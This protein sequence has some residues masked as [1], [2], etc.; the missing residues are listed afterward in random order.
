[1]TNKISLPIKAKSDFYVPFDPNELSS[2]LVDRFEKQVTLYPSNIALKEGNLR[3]TYSELNNRANHI[4][5][6]I[7][8]NHKDYRGPIAFLLDHGI[9][10]IFAIFGIL[11]S[12]N[13]YLALDSDFPVERLE[14]MLAD[15]GAPLV[16]TDS[17]N[18]DFCQSFTKGG[19]TIVN[20]DTIDFT[21][22]LDNPNLDIPLEA[23]ALLQYTSGSTGQPK[24]CILPHKNMIHLSMV[25][26]REKYFHSMD[27]HIYLL[28]ASFAAHIG[29][30]FNMLLNGGGVYP[31]DVKK[32]GLKK[33]AD[34]LVKEKITVF[35]AIPS[36]FRYFASMIDESTQF[37]DLRIL[38]LAGDSVLKKDVELFNKFFPTSCYFINQLGGTE[39]LGACNYIIP[40]GTKING[41]IVPVGY[42]HEGKKVLL[43]DENGDMVSTGEVGEIVVQSHYLSPGY[44]HRQDLTD[45]VFQSVP[46]KEN[47]FQYKTGDLGRRDEDGCLYHLGR[48]DNQVKIR[49]YRV[50]LAEII[51]RLHEYPF[52]KDAYVHAVTNESGEKQLIAYLVSSEKSEKII[53]RINRDL[54]NGLPSYM[55]PMYFEF[56]DELP[57]IPAGKIDVKKLPGPK[58]DQSSLQRDYLP[59]RNF[60]ERK[61]VEIWESLLDVHPIGIK[62]SFTELGGHSLSA[63][64]LIAELENH[65]DVTLPLS[66]L[67]TIQTIE[68]LAEVLQDDTR[69]TSWSHLVTLQPQGDKLPFFCIPAAGITALSFKKL[70]DYMS[71]DRPI[72]GIDYVGMDGKSDP[73]TTIPEIAEYNISLM[74]SVQPE[75]PYCLSGMCFGAVVAYEMAHQ[76]LKGG[77]KVGFLGVLDA[78]N[79]PAQ[80]IPLM[81]KLMKAGVDLNDKVFRGKL[82]IKLRGLDLRLNQDSV[83]DSLLDDVYRVF[84][85]HAYAHLCYSSAQL[86]STITLFMTELEHPERLRK[87]WQATTTKDLDVVV[88]PGVHGPLS[89]NV[90]EMGSFMDE[91]NVQTLAKL[92]MDKLDNVH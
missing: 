25:N 20:L 19:S 28:S 56:L 44:W 62:E 11:K 59:P 77:Q 74:K 15:S 9:N 89:R 36:T 68:E 31:Y 84:E 81:A 30:V 46:G 22:S 13:G 79:L 72:Y 57:K 5:F 91:P 67:V 33:L 75:G 92:L 54:K 88:I 66:A 60:Y 23:L 64:Q 42:E 83:D 50:E 80:K 29:P 10:Q 58:K 40:H 8:E 18:L 69:L 47:L 78:R 76:L 37:P 34:F 24:G 35:S 7:L 82:P 61:L 55:V 2:T 21:Q 3:F 70:V 53:E 45:A 49:G 48:K 63:L 17:K 12:G 32:E 85:T 90:D 71:K 65:F 26:N 43:L 86:P 39:F 1:M 87:G 27:R 73:H 6:K 38:A 4:A 16:V 52:I 14:F 41:S 51:T